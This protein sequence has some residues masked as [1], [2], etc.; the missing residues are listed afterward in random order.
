MPQLCN[1]AKNIIFSSLTNPPFCSFFTSLSLSLSL[2]SPFSAPCTP[3]IWYKVLKA[4][5]VIIKK[6]DFVKW[7]LVLLF[8]ETLFVLI[9]L[10]NLWFFL[11]LSKINPKMITLSSMIMFLLSLSSHLLH[12]PTPSM[13]GLFLPSQLLILMH[14]HHHHHINILFLL[15]YFFSWELSLSTF[16]NVSGGFQLTND[17]IF[18][19]VSWFVYLLLVF[20]FQIF[21]F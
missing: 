18:C 16:L 7:V 5:V 20:M 12:H 15:I 6:S 1:N 2:H 9:L 8:I 13:V 10:I 11:H 4:F 14:H 21:N 17:L 19:G 3:F